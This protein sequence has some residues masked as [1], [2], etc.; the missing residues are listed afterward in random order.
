[1]FETPNGGNSK[2]AT[3]WTG[4]FV[5][6]VTNVQV[7][8]DWKTEGSD[9][10]V[11]WDPPQETNNVSGTSARFYTAQNR[12]IFSCFRN[13]AQTGRCEFPGVVDGDY[14][15]EVRADG[16]YGSEVRRQDFKVERPIVDTEL[17]FTYD[18]RSDAPGQMYIKLSWTHIESTGTLGLHGVGRRLV[19][20]TTGNED[21]SAFEL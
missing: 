5:P 8:V 12:F 19:L 21:P 14:R 17:D 13:V 16:G 6:S 1:M 10:V 4:T 20:F 15:V 3:A 18:W 9:V 7:A 11:T 2:A